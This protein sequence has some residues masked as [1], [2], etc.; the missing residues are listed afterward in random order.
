M[1]S[2][3]SQREVT[4]AHYEKW[5]K[6]LVGNKAT[7]IKNGKEKVFLNPADIFFNNNGLRTADDLKKA[8]DQGMKSVGFEWSTYTNSWRVRHPEVLAAYKSMSSNTQELAGK[9]LDDA[10][11]ARHRLYLMFRDMHETFHGDVNAF[12]EKLFAKM[13]K[14]RKEL[15]PSAL[16]K[17][18]DEATWNQAAAKMSLHDFEDATDGFRIKGTI[19]T[20]IDF[21]NFDAENIFRLYGNRAMEFMDNQVTGIFRQP[22]VMVTYAALRKKYAGLEKAFA[23]QQYDNMGGAWEKVGTPKNPGW[24]SEATAIAEKRFTEI[25]TRDAADTVLKYADNPTIR[26]NA[27]F[28]GRTIGRYYRATEDFYRRIYRMKDVSPRVLYRMR[29][30]HLGLD[31][32]GM[33]HI[34]TN[35]EPYIMMPMDNIIFKATDTVIRTLT[36]GRGYSQPSFNEFTLKLRMMNPSFSQDSGLPTLSGPIAGLSVIAVKDILSTIPGKIPFIGQFIDPAAKQLAE[37]IDTFALGNIG[38]NM[39]IT[40]AIVPVGLQRIY[41]MLPVNEKNR[42]EVTA[43]QQAIAYNAAHGLFID[44]NSTDQEKAAYLA[45]VRISAHNVLFLRNFLGLIGPVAP[46]TMETKGV[47]DY[48]KDTGITGLRAE[49]FDILNGISKTNPGEVFDPYELALATFTGENPGKLIYTV[50]RDSRQT[51]VLITNTQE[52]KTWGIRNEKLIKQYGEAA[53]IFAPKVGTFNAS[54]YKWLQAA[55]LTKNKNLEQYYNDILVA[56]DKQAYYDIA[57]NEKQMLATMSDPEARANLIKQATAARNSLKAGNPLLTPALIG[58]GNNIGGEEVMLNSVE[59]IINDPSTPVESSTRQRMQ[60]AIKMMRNYIAFCT[61]PQLSN[62]TNSVQIKSER[63][64]Q[65]EADLKKLMTGDAYLIEANRAIF[66]SIL[67]FYSRDSYYAF[68]ETM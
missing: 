8:L 47:P 57:R 46:S 55:G 44:S 10:D 38:D 25:A 48:I 52:L 35:G 41:A 21:G 26:S 6:M 2:R 11:S 12:N 33:T 68:K 17:G 63:R 13:A 64:Q 3:L 39:D 59:Q 50:S 62:A 43:A 34:D 65:I 18:Y 31:S 54:T 20:A 4:L 42:Q 30:S 60:V 66:K 16:A 24:W 37:G 40:K 15:K 45:N 56:E 36:G 58:H 7:I 14:N 27:A 49:F 29:L 51:K 9:G 53:Y 1:T 61:N 32:S 23:K 19:N 5:Y 67:N 22:A 28:A